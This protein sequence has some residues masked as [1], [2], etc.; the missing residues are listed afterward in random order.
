V[1]NFQEDNLVWFVDYL[2]EARHHVNL[3]HRMLKFVS[4]LSTVSI[5]QV[6]LPANA[7]VNSEAYAQLIQHSQH[8]IQFL[9]TILPLIFIRLPLVALVKC[10]AAPSMASQFVSNVY[11]LLSQ[12]IL[13]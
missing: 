1:E 13:Q 9:L 3:S 6:P 7:Y 10:I 8:P 12:K 5:L 11:E 2:D 4:R